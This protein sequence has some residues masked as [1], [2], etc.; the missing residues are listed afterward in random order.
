MDG[1][2]GPVG[3]CGVVDAVRLDIGV[4]VEEGEGVD[5]VGEG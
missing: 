4:E 2:G 5:L 1:A 3:V